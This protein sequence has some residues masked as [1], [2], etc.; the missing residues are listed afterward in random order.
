MELNLDNSQ[1][2][3]FTLNLQNTLKLLINLS[4]QNSK[5][6]SLVGNQGIIQTICQILQLRQKYSSSSIFHDF[7]IQLV[8]FLINIVETDD[9]NRIKFQNN[10]NSVA[11]RTRH[12]KRKNQ[13]EDLTIFTPLNIIVDFFIELSIEIS[14]DSNLNEQYE[15]ATNFFF[16]SFASSKSKVRHLKRFFFLI[17]NST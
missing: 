13:N 5:A 15:K 16:P 8:G 3:C 12:Q 6:C 11:K 10:L 2:N 7:I 1:N 4:H 14:K 9:G 17:F